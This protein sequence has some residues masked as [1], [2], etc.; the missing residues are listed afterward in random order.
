MRIYINE[1][2]LYYTW[3]NTLE[4]ACFPTDVTCSLKNVLF[5]ANI[6]FQTLF[7]IYTTK[8]FKAFG[9]YISRTWEQYI[10]NVNL[11]KT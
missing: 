6:N 8:D 2:Y 7:R 3:F 10:R 4:V 1:L 5:I 9:I 11:S